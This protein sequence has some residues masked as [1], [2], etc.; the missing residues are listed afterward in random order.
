[1]FPFQ[2]GANA[3]LSGG[4]PSAPGPFPGPGGGMFPPSGMMGTPMPQGGAGGGGIGRLLSGLFNRGGSA[5]S[6]AANSTGGMMGPGAFMPNSMSGLGTLGNAANALSSAS[7]GTRGILGTIQNIQKVVQVGQQ[8]MPMVQQ[9]GPLVKNVPAMINM[10]KSIAAAT[11]DKEAEETVEE[12]A[13]DENEETEEVTSSNEEGEADITPKETANPSKSKNKT[14]Q[15]KSI[16]NR[17]FT[18]KSASQRR[19][20]TVKG[21]AIRE[22]QTTYEFNESDDFKSSTPLLY[23]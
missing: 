18:P 16:N 23:V 12:T 7:S 2:Q 15:Q 1:M 5:A 4:L 11:D 17:E 14:T 21:S 13:V 9:F 19:G 8:I 6:T 20:K 22:S 3:G 10:V